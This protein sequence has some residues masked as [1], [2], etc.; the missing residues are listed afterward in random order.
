M[1][2]RNET[3]TDMRIVLDGSSFYGCTFRS[4]VLIYCATLPVVMEGCQYER[5]CRWQ[6]DRAA[7]TTLDFLATLYRAGATNLVENTFDV[8]RGKPPKGTTVM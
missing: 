3:F 8:I 7:K 6:M 5:G 1:L 4:C 2:A